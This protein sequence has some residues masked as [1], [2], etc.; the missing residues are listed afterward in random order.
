M[1]TRPMTHPASQELAA[2]AQ[3]QLADA[4]AEIIAG[5]LKT[6]TS[7]RQ[8][9]QA[10]SSHSPSKVPSSVGSSSKGP[11]ERTASD[12]PPD[13]EPPVPALRALPPELANHP[14]FKIV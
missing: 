14:K 2:Y 5:H 7:C 11:A 9:V 1:H 4:A 13:A 8:V 12:L 10:S 3:G 6:C